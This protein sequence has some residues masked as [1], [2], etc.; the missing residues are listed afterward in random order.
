MHQYSSIAWKRWTWCL[1]VFLVLVVAHLVINESFLLLVFDLCVALKI[2]TQQDHNEYV[3]LAILFIGSVYSFTA[4]TLVVFAPRISLIH[5]IKDEL[6][7]VA[8]GNQEFWK[9]ISIRI[10]LLMHLGIPVCCLCIILLS[11]VLHGGLEGAVFV[12]L[13]GSVIFILSMAILFFRIQSSKHEGMGKVIG[14]VVI[15]CAVLPVFSIQLAVFFVVILS[16]IIFGIT[17]IFMTR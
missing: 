5:T 10:T 7:L 8:N 4:S 14:L 15:G 16:I 17:L 9:I 2:Y 13:Y 6:R 3:S 11:G 1:Q 12:L